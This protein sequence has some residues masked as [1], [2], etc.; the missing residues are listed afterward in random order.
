MRRSGRAQWF[1]V[2]KKGKQEKNT[3]SYS[4]NAPKLFDKEPRLCGEELRGNGAERQ[5]SG[6]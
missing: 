3:T 5:L 2:G 6:R 1:V 4:R